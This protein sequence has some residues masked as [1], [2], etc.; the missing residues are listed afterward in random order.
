MAMKAIRGP[1]DPMRS[2]FRPSQAQALVVERCSEAPKPRYHAFDALRGMTMFLVVGLH[3]ALGY[4]ERD[5]PHVLWCIRDA[6][7][8]PVFDWFCWWSMGVSNPLYFTIA[9][10][11]A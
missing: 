6:P 2:R 3:A 5:I 1:R 9:G 7:T 4:I 11:F 8:V 10:F